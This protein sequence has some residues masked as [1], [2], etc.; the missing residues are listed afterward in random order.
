MYTLKT[1]PED[2]VVEEKIQLKLDDSGQYV[3]Y[4]LRK[5]EYTTQRALD[6]IA[7]ILQ[8]RVRD[9]G[10]AGNKD[11]VA[12]TKQAI[13]IKDPERR[14]GE[15]NFDG[16]NSD[17]LSL[18]YIGR[19]KNPISLGDLDGNRFEIILRDCDKEP[20]SISQMVN[21][22]DE[23]RFSKTNVQ[24][25]RAIVKKDM[26][27]A[28]LLIRF[29]D[30]ENYLEEN[31]TDFVGAMKKLPLK[32]R[33]LHVHSYQS[34]MWNECVSEYLQCKYKDVEKVQYS[35]GKFVFSKTTVNNEKVP[36]IGFGSD[37][38]SGEMGKIIREVMKK[39]GL[40]KQDFVIRAMPELSAEG[41][42]RDIAVT[43]S[44]LVIEKTHEKTYKISFTIPK[45]SYAT[46][47][48]K[49]MMEV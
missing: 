47:A 45:G 17:E 39:E 44:K 10:F 16:F 40:T 31:P 29:S 2:F 46:I 6:R 38:A 32:I 26:K 23:Q 37:D 14:L 8:K 49:Q 36:I 18:E 19:G 41:G 35:Q 33:L 12:V 5:K 4:W 30:T 42:S 11:K 27:Q 21:Y 43:V 28:A 22:F 15:N 13:S 24:V 48:I 9:I 25:G 1:K 7:G 20:K 3:Y 34:W